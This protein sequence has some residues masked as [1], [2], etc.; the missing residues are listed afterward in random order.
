MD[1]C[2]RI[3]PS[4]LVPPLLALACSGGC[5]KTT[6]AGPF[7]GPIDLKPHLPAGVSPPA[8]AQATLHRARVE[9]GE[10]PALMDVAWRSFRGGSDAYTLSATAAVYRPSDG[11]HI[12]GIEVEDTGRPRGPDGG[13]VQRVTL[14]IGWG[15]SMLHTTWRCASRQPATGAAHPR[16]RGTYGAHPQSPPPSRAAAA[17]PFPR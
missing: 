2:R 4:A 3:S 9:V 13:V 16:S 6:P 12:N 1:V 11:L 7:G 8:E 10:P 17:A 14:K 15:R 5:S